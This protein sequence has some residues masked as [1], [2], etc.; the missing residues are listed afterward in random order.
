MKDNYIVQ[1]WLIL[2]LAICF[3]AA[4][5]G[6]ELALAERIERNKIDETYSQIPELVRCEWWQPTAAQWQAHEGKTEE[7]VTEQG[8]LAY[9]AHDADGD[10]R[11][12]VIK[13]A[14]QGFADKIEILIGLD[15]SGE[16]VLGLYVLNQKETP[17]LGNKIVEYDW[18]KKF[19]GR[20][21]GRE[22]VV[23]KASVQA[24]KVTANSIQAVTG[25]TVS[26][27]AV[28]GIVNA[29]VADFHTRLDNGEL[30][31]RKKD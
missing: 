30:K 26:S 28:V 9:K 27:N 1:A 23:S 4:L 13:A 10:H 2:A 22:I 25:A 7:W 21:T 20:E 29:A 8:H 5:S 12:W 18:R 16:K 19:V 17:A 3:G 6:I 15:E 14:G 24:D 11:G 31:P